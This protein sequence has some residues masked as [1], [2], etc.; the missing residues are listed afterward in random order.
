MAE[1]VSVP[2]FP[3]RRLGSCH[4]GIYNLLWANETYALEKGINRAGLRTDARAPGWGSGAPG[5]T[6]RRM[7]PGEVGTDRLEVRTRGEWTSDTG[8]T[9]Q[10]TTRGRCFGQSIAQAKV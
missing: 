2:P 3:M 8:R 7:E 6:L 1:E 9:G 4:L 10:K 5:D